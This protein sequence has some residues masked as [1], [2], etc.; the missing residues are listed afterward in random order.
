MTPPKDRK[1]PTGPV[2]S[3]A[4]SQGARPC[5][6]QPALHGPSTSRTQDPPPTRQETET[7]ERETT[8]PFASTNPFQPLQDTNGEEMEAQPS[9]PKIIRP[10]PIFV[11]NIT[12]F[13]LMCSQLDARVG[14]GKY[15]CVNRQNDTKIIPDSSDSYR[16]I[17]KY[18]QETGAQHHTY[19]LKE[20]R[21]LRVVI[22]HLHHTTPIEA[23]K[24]ELSE[25]GFIVKNAINV[26][27]TRPGRDGPSKTPLPMFFIDLEPTANVNEIYELTTLY[28]CK[29]KVEKPHPRRDIV[30]CYRCQEY[31][32]TKS[33]CNYNSRCVKCGGPH[34]SSDCPKPR[35]TPAT[36]A[37]C[38]N[39]HPA[40]Y[41][42]CEVYQE[43]KQR[44]QPS[45]RIPEMT[46]TPRQRAPS[47]TVQ[48]GLSFAQMAGNQ[49]AQHPTRPE[50][51]Q[52]QREPAPRRE[53]PVISSVPPPP[54]NDSVLNELQSTLK[55]FL[56]EFQALIT[57]LITLLSAVSKLI[58]T[59][60]P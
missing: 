27:S 2:N 11:R 12:N 4:L 44:T 48:P 14:R 22:R 26:I 41:K 30:Q 24:E 51:P 25:L 56:T 40:N 53:R 9:T 37:L 43:L 32:H 38:N 20:E 13:H 59:L 6:A 23:I 18:L 34:M 5:T 7:E 35:T 1:R 42:G 36:C 15:T 16:A 45:R 31:G 57:P 8:S 49:P 19:Q 60:N 50:E 47:R 29:I 46:T 52:P 54:S 58:P 55:S 3:K 28:H 10:P 39:S 33:F 21:A 17:I